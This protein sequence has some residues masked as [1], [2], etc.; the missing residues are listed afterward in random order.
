MEKVLCLV[1][2]GIDSPLACALAARSFEVIPLHFCLHPYVDEGTLSATME[3]LKNLQRR[4]GF[5]R[6]LVVPWS[7]ALR[8]ISE[9]GGKYTCVLCKRGMFRVAEMIAEAENC[10]AMVTGESLGQKASQTVHNLAA[11]S[12][13]LRIP[14][15]RPLLAMD[16][17]EI[18]RLAK[19]VGVWSERHAG[20]CSF[21]PRY[22]STRARIEVIDRLFEKIGLGK[23]LE[24]VREVRNLEEEFCLFEER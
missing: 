14:V 10:S 15:L 24:K 2:G 6:L 21:V 4:V 23:E 18:E 22:P 8:R 19:E 3:V 9:V 13:G 5:K 17:L 1:S 7:E 11:T 12:A 20:F 16:K